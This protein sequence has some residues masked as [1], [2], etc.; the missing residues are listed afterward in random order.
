M[1]SLRV[2]YKNKKFKKE[3]IQDASQAKVVK[4][5]ISILYIAI[6]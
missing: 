1:L 4:Y 6:L 3:I 2:L 5:V